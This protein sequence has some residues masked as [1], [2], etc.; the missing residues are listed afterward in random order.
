MVAGAR[1]E[2]IWKFK[3]QNIKVSSES[4]ISWVKTKL[5]FTRGKME[6]ALD[7][8][9]GQAEW[10]IKELRKKGIIKRTGRFEYKIGKGQRQVIYKYL[11]NN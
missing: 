9:L 8:T 6:K 7:L 10:W 5:E 4:V 1:Y 11:E 3:K 2:C